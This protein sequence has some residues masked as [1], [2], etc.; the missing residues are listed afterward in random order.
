M[1]ST[2]SDQEVT[3]EYDELV[4]IKNVIVL[5]RENID[6]LVK[7]VF[8]NFCFQNFGHRQKTGIRRLQ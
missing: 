2:D 5:L 6:A 8:K 1:S 7:I 4:N 3:D